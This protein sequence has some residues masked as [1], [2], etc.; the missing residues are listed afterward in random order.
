MIINKE[1]PSTAKYTRRAAITKGDA[2]ANFLTEKKIEFRYN[3]ILSALFFKENGGEWRRMTD[4]EELRLLRFVRREHKPTT[5]EVFRELVGSSDFSLPYNPLKDYINSLKLKPFVNGLDPF[6]DL[7]RYF[8]TVNSS[9][10]ERF[11]LIQGFRS[12]YVGLVKCLFVSKY[13]HKQVLILKGPQGI[14]KTPFVYSILPE[15][16]HEYVY[17]DPSLSQGGI[18]DSKYLLTA[19]LIGVIDELDDWLKNRDNKN[20]Y[21]KHFT[22]PHVNVRR[23]W[24]R[25]FESKPRIS[26][27]VSTCNTSNFLDDPTGT[28]R[29]LVFNI[30]AI[31]NEK[32]GAVEKMEDFDMEQLLAYAAHLFKEGFDPEFTKEQLEINERANE[33]FKFNSVEFE[34]LQ[35][36]F[37]QVDV[38]EG[39]FYTTT[40][41]VKTLKG[42]E[43]D[44]SF[45]FSNRKIGSALTRLKWPKFQKVKKTLEGKRIS[46]SGYYLK[47]TDGAEDLEQ[48]EYEQERNEVLDSL[49][50]Q[51]QTFNDPT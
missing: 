10:E 27:F 36:H 8:I 22:L 34:L 9:K 23:P 32:Y 25:Y 2:L 28:T 31:K 30:K 18:K 49:F 44:F 5:R 15:F 13:V 1:K 47:M 29:M 11:R 14:G 3:V 35:K 7:S 43:P 38:G 12:W 45:S 24:G 16:L 4:G 26:S 41:I 51:T 17:E 42:L 33:E 48:V 46:S 6:T 20:N 50:P 39:D 40:D 19:G 37:R 21:K